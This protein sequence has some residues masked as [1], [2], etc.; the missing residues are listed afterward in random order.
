VSL[1]AGGASYLRFGVALQDDGYLGLSSQG[2]P[3]SATAATGEESAP[4][5]VLAADPPAVSASAP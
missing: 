1:L 2:A 3:L 5:A 4:A